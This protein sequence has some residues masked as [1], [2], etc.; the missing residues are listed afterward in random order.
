MAPSAPTPAIANVLIAAESRVCENRK[1]TAGHADLGEHLD[2][3]NIGKTVTADLGDA[4]A[5]EQGGELAHDMIGAEWRLALAQYVDDLA[6]RNF[7]FRLQSF[8]PTN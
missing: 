3:P 5:L 8:I 2:W 7:P 4:V 6:N 1:L